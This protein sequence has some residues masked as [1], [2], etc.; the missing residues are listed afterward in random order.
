M[1]ACT[2]VVHF[3]GIGVE[4]SA[5]PVVCW[6]RAGWLDRVARTRLA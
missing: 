5:S 6:Q 4:L 1:L 2:V 3:M